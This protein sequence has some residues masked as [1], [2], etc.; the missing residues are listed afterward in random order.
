M[1]RDIP[2][3][4]ISFILVF[5]F[6]A[7]AQ[8]V[9][10]GIQFGQIGG[11]IDLA[12]QVTGVLV[13][14]NGGVGAMTSAPFWARNLGDGSDG[15]ETCTSALTNI[16]N[17]FTSFTVAN[18]Q[19][20]SGPANGGMI[21]H[22]TGTCTIAGTIRS[23][24]NGTAL[25]GLYGGSGG[26]GGGGTL[27]S[28][29]ARGSG[30]GQSQSNFST[31]LLAGGVASA[32]SGGVGIAG[33]SMTLSQARYAME[34]GLSNSLWFNGGGNGTAG[35]S[36]GGAL[37]AGA[38]PVV[39]E[40]NTINF[41][42]TIN[43][44]GYP[45]TSTSTSTQGGGGGGGGAMVVLSA[46]TYTSDAGTIITG[47]GQGGGCT[48][49]AVTLTSAD[50]GASV[51]GST[52]SVGNGAYAEV[53]TVSAGNPTV[54]TV[55]AGGSGYVNP[56]TCA[57]SGGGGSGATCSCTV[58]AGAVNACT[59]TGGNAGYTLTNAS[60]CGIGGYGGNGPATVYTIQ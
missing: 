18:G 36:S 2:F 1:K 12:T 39:F 38:Q 27:A 25:Y 51:S 55:E 22:A 49:P 54:I 58:S 3:L 16:E 17:Y 47:G 60:T 23:N 37:G 56:P 57:I 44:S 48:A 13:P 15:A 46:I 34:E 52:V 9:S 53:T 8:I 5:A 41:T 4:V 59:V 7:L 11:T 19:T 26:S 50:P 32:A 43:A 35:G 42:G 45:G 30:P 33:A 21:V 31:Y 40:C 24:G 6:S 10:S 14:A 20:C 29:A 28:S